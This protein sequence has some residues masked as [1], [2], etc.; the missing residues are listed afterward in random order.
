MMTTHELAKWLLG[1][2]ECPV[3]LQDIGVGGLVEVEPAIWD[4]PEG[5]VAVI[6]P[7]PAE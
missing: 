3:M 6:E 7:K 4:L 5:S 1:Q 2:V